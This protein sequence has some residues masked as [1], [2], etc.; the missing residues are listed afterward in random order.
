MTIFI[1][2]GCNSYNIIWSGILAELIPMLAECICLS[3]HSFVCTIILHRVRTI[4]G[5]RMPSIVWTPQDY[6]WC[7]VSCG[8]VVQKKSTCSCDTLLIV[9]HIVVVHAMLSFP[10]TPVVPP[11]LSSSRDVTAFSTHLHGLQDQKSAVIF[12]SLY[13]NVDNG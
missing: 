10:L 1:S 7:P 8:K 12:F 3:I 6:L 11:L 2:Y 13:T 9:L 4:C 5:A